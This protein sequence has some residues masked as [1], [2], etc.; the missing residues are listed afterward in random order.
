M[1]NVL[2]SRSVSQLGGQK[3]ETRG[4][5]L[6][7]ML[8]CSVDALASHLGAAVNVFL[9]DVLHIFSQLK[10]IHAVSVTYLMSLVHSY[11]NFVPNYLSTTLDV[12][13]RYVLKT[14]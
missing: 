1:C 10:K 14:G 12:L 5:Y 9:I 8:R 2:R 6:A 11:T 7:D 13:S 4:A 3:E